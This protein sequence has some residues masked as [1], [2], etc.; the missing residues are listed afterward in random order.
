MERCVDDNLL[1][2]TETD[3]HWWRVIDLLDLVGVSGMICNPEKFQFSQTV[4]DFAG[5]RLTE[6]SVEPLPKYLDA[7]RS[8]PVPKTTTDI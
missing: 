4:A 5:F 2:D 1:H 6:D 8:F 7:I 3:D